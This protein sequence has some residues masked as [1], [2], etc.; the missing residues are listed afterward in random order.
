MIE[1]GGECGGDS[2]GG[3]GGDGG[4]SGGGDGSCAFANK[5]NPFPPL[6]EDSD[7]LLSLVL[8]L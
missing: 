2:G 8:L 3:D 4:G 1:G 6:K 7:D 5:K